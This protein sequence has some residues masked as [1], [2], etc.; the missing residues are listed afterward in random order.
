[1]TVTAGAPQGAPAEAK[2]FLM[3]PPEYF[4]VEYAINPWMNPDNPVDVQLAIRQWE[5]LRATYL[6][7]GHTVHTIAPPV[8]TKR[9]GRNHLSKNFCMAATGL[10]PGC[11]GRGCSANLTATSYA[12]H[13]PIASVFFLIFKI[14]IP[15]K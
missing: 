12:D 3:C 8:R 10:S 15:C 13:R 11:P 2:T 9:K 4:A 6:S 1:M 14:S 5:R 7:L